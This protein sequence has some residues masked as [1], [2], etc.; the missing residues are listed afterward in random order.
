M[1]PEPARLRVHF[2]RVEFDSND[3]VPADAQDEISTALRN[4]VSE[5]DADSAYLKDLASEIAEVSVRGAL[6]NRGY[7]KATA[8]ANL[9]RLQTQ[10]ADIS[11]VAAIRARLGPQYRMGGLRIENAESGQPLAISP[12]VLRGLI[13]LQKGELFNVER[14]RTGLQNFALAYGRKGYVDMTPEPETEVD[15]ER[16]TIDLTLRIDQQ[17]Q[18]RVGNVELLGVS[19]VTR[20]KL[21]ESLPNPGEVFDRTKLDEFFKVNRAIL[22]PDVSRDDVIV[23]RDIK[24]RTVRVLFDLRVCPQQSN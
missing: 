9:T 7:F 3:G 24:M 20:D 12:D 21:M 15:D 11:V 4:R 17:V 18:Y 23:E 1:Q 16:G 14:I 22:P 2:I 13:P 5:P 19:G 8:T 6:R 10:G